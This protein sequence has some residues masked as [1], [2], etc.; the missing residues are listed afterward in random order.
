MKDTKTCLTCNRVLPAIAFNRSTRCG[1]QSKCR[2]CQKVSRDAGRST[3]EARDREA[4]SCRR[5]KEINK[6]RLIS[7]RKEYYDSHKEEFANNRRKRYILNPLYHWAYDTIRGHERRGFDVKLTHFDLMEI[8]QNETHCPICG[9]RYVWR[10]NGH[11]SMHKP[12]LDRLNNEKII[13]KE[14]VWVICSRCNA[15]KGDRSMKE[16]V[17]YCKKV[18]SE[19]GKIRMDESKEVKA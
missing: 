5:Y 1:L 14:N 8:A 4:A 6:E 3:Q 7:A 11:K 2:E 13:N 15:T 10:G 9:E 18:A 16:F 12:S 17:E 19:F